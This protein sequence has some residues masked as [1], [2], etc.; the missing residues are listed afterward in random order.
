M[1]TF[2]EGMLAEREAIHRIR[3]RNPNMP[4]RTLA[5][6]I[7]GADFDAERSPAEERNFQDSCRVAAGFYTI[8]SRLR[9]YDKKINGVKSAFREEV[10]LN[11]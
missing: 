6:R 9:R 7:N 1:K 10:G 5:R 4:L 2:D 3:V 8:Y 11:G